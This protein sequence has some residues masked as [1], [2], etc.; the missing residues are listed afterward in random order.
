M[1]RPRFHLAINL[2]AG[3]GR[4]V[5]GSLGTNGLELRECAPLHVHAAHC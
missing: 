2:G 4:A 5:L 1:A 3:S